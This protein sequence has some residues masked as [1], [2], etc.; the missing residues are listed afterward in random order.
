MKNL[1]DLLFGFAGNVAIVLLYHQRPRQY[2]CYQLMHQDATTE[3]DQQIPQI[4]L[5]YN[6]TK[7]GVN[8]KDHLATIFYVKEK[9]N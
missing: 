2:Y 9:T 7:S 1:K 3:G 8:N 4:V 6:K 5:P